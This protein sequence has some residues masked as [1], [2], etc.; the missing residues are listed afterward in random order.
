MTVRDETLFEMAYLNHPA[1]GI[2][3]CNDTPGQ[4]CQ[5]YDKVAASSRTMPNMQHSDDM[6]K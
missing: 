2:L 4:V 1:V 5:N 3:D 6:N